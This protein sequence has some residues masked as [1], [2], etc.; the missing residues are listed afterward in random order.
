[1]ISP[2]KIFWNFVSK[3]ASLEVKAVSRRA[4]ICS[5][6]ESSTALMEIMISDFRS[7]EIVIVSISSS[8][9]VF[10]TCFFSGLWLVLLG[11]EL[12]LSNPRFA[13]EPLSPLPFAMLRDIDPILQVVE[14]F[15]MKNGRADVYFGERKNLGAQ[16]HR[17]RKLLGLN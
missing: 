11:V 10:L 14:L 9:G 2:S 3:S 5:S 15:F 1:M 7:S 6:L 12:T 13:A 4:V 8:S 16:L 17:S